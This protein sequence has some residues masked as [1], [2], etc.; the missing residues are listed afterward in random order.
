[1]D[2]NVCRKVATVVNSALLVV[3]L[4]GPVASAAPKSSRHPV[5]SAAARLA[6]GCR[7][8]NPLAN[9]Y[10][11]YRLK[12][13]IGCLTVTGTVAYVRREADGDIHVDVRL[14]SK[15]SGLL[16]RAN[17][18][19][20]R[21]NLVTEIVPADQP[22]CTRGKPPRPPHGS[23]NFG[24]CT[25]ADIATPLV[26][27]RVTVTGPYVLDTNHGWM[28]IH[29]VWAITTKRAI[30]IPTTTLATM[31]ARCR[32]TAMPSSD[33]YVGDYD[34]FVYSNQPYH[35]ATASDA[36]DTWT[37][38][39]NGAGYANIRLWNTAPGEKITVTVGRASCSVNA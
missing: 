26:G 37:R 6:R 30:P 28:E 15:E 3:V 10:H 27:T 19:D 29:P 2:A 13:R 20:Q 36:G 9:V 8:G 25:G 5:P 21:G 32:A 23:Y 24:I 1:M 16:N 14:T 35:V 18:A 11:S 12:V 39:T 31:T 7:G 4:F 22:G 38:E 34:V 33:G 17:R